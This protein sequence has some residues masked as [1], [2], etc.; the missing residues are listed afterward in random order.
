MALALALW[1]AFIILLELWV[2]FTTEGEDQ[3]MVP[4]LWYVGF[5]AIIVP[6][7]VFGLYSLV[8]WLI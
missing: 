4:V 3:M 8:T 6:W 1:S 5:L 2:T 7:G